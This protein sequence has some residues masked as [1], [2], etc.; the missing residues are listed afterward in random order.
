MAQAIL[1]HAAVVRRFES[2][3]HWSRCDEA[4]SPLLL[5]EIIAGSFRIDQ[6][7]KDRLQDILSYLR[8]DTQPRLL[9]LDNFETPWDIEGCQSGITD[10]LLALTAI[11]YLA[12]PVTM[13]GT[14]PG[15]GRMKWSKSEIP[16]LVVL[17][18]EAAREL[19]VEIDSKANT[20][21]NLTALLSELGHMPLA[22]MLMARVGSEGEMPT[23]MLKRWRSHGTDLLHEPGGD[24]RTS[25]KLSIEISLRSNLIKS[26]PD[27]LKLLS[28]LAVLPGGIRNET[29]TDLGPDISDP[30]RARTALLRASL[31]F[32]SPETNSLYV[33]APIRP[34]I[35]HHHMATPELWRSLYGFSYDYLK[36]HPARVYWEQG[37]RTDMQA[38]ASEEAN[39]QTVLF[40]TLEHDPSDVAITAS[41]DFT[42]YQHSDPRRLSSD[43]ARAAVKASRLTRTKTQLADS[44]LALGE[45]FHSQD[46]NKDAR[47]TLE[48]A[49][50]EYLRLDDSAG[51]ARCLMVLADVACIEDRWT[52]AER[53][54]E[55]THNEYEHLGNPSGA[56]NSLML[57]GEILAHLGR[58]MTRNAPYQWPSDGKAVRRCSRRI[59]AHKEFVQLED[60]GEAAFCLRGL[61]HVARFDGRYEDA[62]KA[63]EGARTEFLRRC[64][65]TRDIY[66]QAHVECARIGRFKESVVY[67]SRLGDL[68]CV[69]GLYDEARKAYSRAV[70]EYSQLGETRG[71]GYSKLTLVFMDYKEDQLGSAQATLLEARGTLTPTGD[72]NGVAE[73][74]KWLGNIE[75]RE[76]RFEDARRNFED[77]RHAFEQLGQLDDVAECLQGLGDAGMAEGRYDDGRKALKEALEEF[78]RL[79]IQKGV[80]SC[81]ISL[82]DLGLKEGHP[83][84]GRSSLEEARG[85]Y[86]GVGVQDRDRS[87]RIAFLAGISS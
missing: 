58:Y 87:R 10:I 69:Q 15:V 19:Y 44:L 83:D 26:N 36:K 24:R 57:W 85:I 56:A 11:P 51:N 68:L 33:L 27:A 28:V 64:T 72:A 25:V 49:S 47:P 71:V 22:V 34:Y 74:L 50:A 38:L 39:I 60:L 2:R 21:V 70:Q 84:K 48:D 65:D 12:I 20:D 53:I 73:C 13:R 61:G 43:V 6:P 80:A 42:R 77:A 1:E 3:I 17:A 63:Y 31:I 16:P 76:G 23:E 9:V 78:R 55:E 67:L 14:L 4:S 59:Q 32:C 75:W 46:R 35:D 45:I 8:S 30:M 40:H 7:S 29:I 82:G 37:Y 79:N 5:V 52:D 66:E 54:I 86:E 81:L 41:L 18:P 62:Y